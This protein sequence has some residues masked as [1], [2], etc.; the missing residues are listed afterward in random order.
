MSDQ[1][2]TTFRLRANPCSFDPRRLL[3][4]MKKYLRARELSGY[5]KRQKI[6]AL[7]SI[8][9]QM[10]AEV[11]AHGKAVMTPAFLGVAAAMTQ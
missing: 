3:S 9:L 6:A 11:Q 8:R 1:Q 5:P 7:N 2:K 10:T 4:Q